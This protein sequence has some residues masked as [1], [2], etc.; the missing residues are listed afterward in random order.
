MACGSRARD[1]QTGS[2]L[3]NLTVAGRARGYD[4]DVFDILQPSLNLRN[5]S[6]GDAAEMLSVSTATVE[7]ASK[8]G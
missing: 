2:R 1:F 8:I 6:Q 5:V 4:R 3:S 7:D